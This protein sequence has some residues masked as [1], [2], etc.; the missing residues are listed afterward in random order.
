MNA[1]K[2]KVFTGEYNCY[3]VS[4]IDQQLYDMVTERPVPGAPMGIIG[5]SASLHHAAFIGADRSVWA[6]GDNTTNMTGTGASSTPVGITKTPVGNAKQV[7]AYCNGGD[8]NKLG[9]GIAVLTMDGK[10]ILLGNT[11]SG[12]R[13]D[14][15]E[16]NQ[17]ESAPFQ[18][19][20]PE[21]II[22]IAVGGY[23]F[24]I[25]VSGKVYQWGGTRQDGWWR[26]FSAGRYGTGVSQDFTKVVVLN[27][28]EAI[29]DIVGGG[30]A[31]LALG[32]SGT[33]YAWAY[34]PKYVG[35]LTQAQAQSFFNLTTSLKL[36]TNVKKIA[37]G[38]EA[39][40][41][42]TTDGLLYSWGNNTQAACGNGQEGKFANYG[43][44]WGPLD[45][46]SIYVS[47]P[48][49]INSNPVLPA[50]FAF[51]NIF[52]DIG[53]A[54]YAYA[55]GSDG[56]LYAW[57]R[58][59]AGVIADGKNTGSSQDQS[60]YPN[61]WDVLSPEKL[62]VF[63]SVA[64]PTQPP[65]NQPPTAVVIPVIHL[66]WPTN[67]VQ[68]DGSGSTDSDGTI[69]SYKWTVPAG[70]IIS[71]QSAV[72][73]VFIFPGPGAYFITLT[74]TDNSGATG[75]GTVQVIIAAA[76]VPVIPPPR[77]VSDAVLTVFGSVVDVPLSAL[78]FT[79]SDGGTQ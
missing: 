18:V 4:P 42:L 47:P 73:P 53:D 25:G 35:L 38:P 50:G 28:P 54:F 29:V 71:D 55:E 5:G 31:N 78:K 27:L 19:A 24:A 76:P 60:N 72:K 9:N 46:V 75:S 11:Q 39:C 17:A 51:L 22:K 8:P 79:F 36:P 15:T 70:V 58:N 45:G 62:T 66:T 7:V 77:T 49:L 2:F 48:Y 37:I 61:K 10:I 34:N 20:L 69:T 40:Y 21:P 30:D 41:L 16:G 32:T 59:K 74:V 23:C 52:A 13:G 56:Y 14:G 65:A 12:F 68:I 43:A 26:S 63:P 44:P 3:V 57:G 67:G 1:S 6:I 33:L 64:V